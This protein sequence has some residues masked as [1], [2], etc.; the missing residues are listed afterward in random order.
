MGLAGNNLC[1]L[2]GFAA[3]PIIGTKRF[4]IFLLK[5][6]IELGAIWAKTN[7]EYAFLDFY[8]MAQFLAFIAE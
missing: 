8:I 7:N 6:D 3:T 5:L 4:P 2:I 1:V